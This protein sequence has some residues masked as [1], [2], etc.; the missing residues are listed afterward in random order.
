VLEIQK[1]GQGQAGGV[2]VA[3]ALCQMGWRE[4]IYT[5]QLDDENVF[6]QQVGL[7]FADDLT[8]VGYGVDGLGDDCYPP[9]SA[10]A[11]NGEGV[12]PLR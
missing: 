8:F 4:T 3:E 11:G 5:F 2:E 9:C 10:S 7:V 6:N 1:K 12:Q